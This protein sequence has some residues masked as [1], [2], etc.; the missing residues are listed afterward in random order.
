[1]ELAVDLEEGDTVG[2]VVLS[3]GHGK[4][5]KIVAPVGRDLTTTERSWTFP[6]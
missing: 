4:H 5:K 2:G 1:M 6:E 3:Q